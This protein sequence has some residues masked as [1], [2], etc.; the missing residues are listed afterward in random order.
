[1]THTLNTAGIHRTLIITDTSA[2][3]KSAQLC[4]EV[5]VLVSWALEVC[6]AE[7]WLLETVSLLSMTD[8]ASETLGVSEAATSERLD[9][10]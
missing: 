5:A 6:S 4:L 2:V 1:M 7:L 9:L 3:I 10:K 8:L